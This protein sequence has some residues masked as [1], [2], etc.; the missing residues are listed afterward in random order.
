MRPLFVSAW[1][2]PIPLLKLAVHF[3]LG[4][5]FCAREAALV[6]YRVIGLWRRE[7][8]PKTSH[9]YERIGPAT[10]AGSGGQEDAG[11]GASGL[12]EIGQGVRIK[13][14]KI[15]IERFAQNAPQSARGGD[16]ATV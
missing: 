5:A 9:L 12:D 8:I 11:Q 6:F 7:A 14:G 15:G 13:Y 2:T 4:R 3:P 16:H 10:D 1:G